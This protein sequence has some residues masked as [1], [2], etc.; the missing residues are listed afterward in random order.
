MID[1][2]VTEVDGVDMRCKALRESDEH[3]HGPVK[4]FTPEEVAEYIKSLNEVK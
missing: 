1:E 3:R 4:E 2:I